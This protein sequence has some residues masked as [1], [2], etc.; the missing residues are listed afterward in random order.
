MRLA[1]YL[2]AKA[3]S[4]SEF[5]RRAGIPQQTVNR[6]CHGEA[7]PR[8]DTMLKIV[9]ATREKPAPDGGTVRFE[10]LIPEA[11]TGESAA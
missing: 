8:G 11:A 5:A 4:E 7:I 2:E 3:E 10:D 9:T 6:V 1:D